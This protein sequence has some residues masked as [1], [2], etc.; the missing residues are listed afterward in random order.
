MK[1]KPP[2]DAAE[3]QRMRSRLRARLERDEMERLFGTRISK[4]AMKAEYVNL[5][6]RCLTL[7]ALLPELKEYQ[8]AVEFLEA[9]EKHERGEDTDFPIEAL[10][11][12]SLA[13][14]ESRVFNHRLDQQVLTGNVRFKFASKE[15]A[16]KAAGARIAEFGEALKPK[17]LP[18]RQGLAVTEWIASRAIDLIEPGP[19]APRF[20]VSQLGFGGPIYTDG[21]AQSEGVQ[22]KAGLVSAFEPKARR[23]EPVQILIGVPG[24]GKTHHAL[25]LMAKDPGR[26]YAFGPTAG[27]REQLARLAEKLGLNK[28]VRVI[29]RMCDLRRRARV[30]VDEASLVKPE[31]IGYTRDVREL[32]LTGDASHGEAK[33]GESLLGSLAALGAP[34]IKLTESHRTSSVTLRFLGQMISAPTQQTVPP[35]ARPTWDRPIRV[36]SS[37]SDTE[38]DE[39]VAEASKRQDS[40]A[41]VW[42]EDLRLRLKDAGVRAYDA[43]MVPGTEARHA[44]VHIPNIWSDWERMPSVPL[45]SFLNSICRAREGAT[46]VNSIRFRKSWDIQ[47]AKRHSDIESLLFAVA[48]EDPRKPRRHPLSN[49]VDDQWRL[50]KIIVDALSEFS[51]K[52]DLVRDWLFVYHDSDSDYYCGAVLVDRA[53]HGISSDMVRTAGYSN[54]EHFK[55]PSDGD[56]DACA[57]MVRER[58]NCVQEQ[59]SVPLEGDTETASN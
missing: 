41:I 1:K 17:R 51:M 43:N 42:S 47:I 34:I 29:K 46:I 5:I 59:W 2:F 40:I 7:E 12:V 25:E 3:R 35:L 11:A 8:T 9:K 55:C 31:I 45:K 36:R 38:F 15:D 26:I 48:Y 20:F 58:L 22:T 14:A 10:Q 53:T 49:L 56:W 57:R 19:D 39:I 32:Y 6:R 54:I 27:S 18:P 50:C 21:S 52:A 44:I 24:A 37:Y 28:R 4:A 13:E 16:F 33:P 30:L 23:N